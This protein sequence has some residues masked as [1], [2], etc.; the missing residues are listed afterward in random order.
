MPEKNSKYYHKTK[1]VGFLILALVTISAQPLLSRAYEAHVINVTAHICRQ[2]ETRTIG[3]WKNH[4]E[5]Y[6][7]ALL[8]QSVGTDPACSWYRYVDSQPVVDEVLDTSSPKGKDKAPKDIHIQLRAQLLGM[9]FNIAY[10]GIGGHFVESEGQTIGQIVAAADILLCDPNA[11]RND[12]EDMKNILDYL[13]NLHQLRYCAT[14]SPSVEP[15]VVTFIIK[16]Q[17]TEAGGDDLTEGTVTECEAGTTSSCFLA[18]PGICAAGTK[19]CSTE[20]FWGECMQDNQ[21]VDEVCGDGLDNDCDDLTDCEDP[22]CAEN[23]SCQQSTPPAGCTVDETQPCET[24]QLGICAAG[25]QTCDENGS[26]GECIQDTQPTDGICDNQL[27][28]N[29][30]GLVDCND[31]FCTEDLSCQTEPTTECEPDTTQSCSTDQPGVCAAG[32]QTCSAD[33]LWGECIQNNQPTDEI[34][35]D[36]LDNNCDGLTDC[37]DTICTENPSCQ[38]SAP[39]TECTAD[40]T[41]PCETGQLGICAAGTKTCSAEGFWGECI[42]TN[43]PV[44]EICDNQLD[45]NCDGVV[46][47]PQ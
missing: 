46:D 26:W 17:T 35:D 22:V 9:K 41:Q 16:E 2:A 37:D 31:E 4:P 27:D 7:P 33:S 47:C 11:T 15:L 34:C 29:C 44:E 40:E 43:Q 42:Q 38:P 6:D 13:N 25:T 23:P 21:P 36:G 3:Y 24:G 20:G 8:P 45:D 12:L 18:Q 5:V 10:Y 14:V 19:I 39:P 1:I 30:D 28:D 32:T